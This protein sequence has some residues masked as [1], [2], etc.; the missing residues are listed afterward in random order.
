MVNSRS[1]D[2]QHLPNL[3]VLTREALD[4]WFHVQ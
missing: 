4:H 1:I 3:H 2:L